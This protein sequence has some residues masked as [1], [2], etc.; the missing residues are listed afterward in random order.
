MSTCTCHQVMKVLIW[1]WWW[2]L[3]PGDWLVVRPFIVKWN[4]LLST[5][6]AKGP[7]FQCL[8][9][10]Q[11]MYISFLLLFT[12]YIAKIHVDIYR[13]SVHTKTCTCIQILD[14]LEAVQIKQYVYKYMSY[15]TNYKYI[16]ISVPILKTMVKMFW[17]LVAGSFI[18]GGTVLCLFSLGC[19]IIFT[20]LVKVQSFRTTNSIIDSCQF[21]QEILL[22]ISGKLALLFNVDLWWHFQQIIRKKGSV[23]PQR[24]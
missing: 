12:R 19:A 24:Q 21:V 17:W 14:A 7:N 22:K 15:Y 10:W 23:L 18:R 5:I 9:K 1:W 20:Y 16:L 2:R 11:I 3:S 13:I 6:K 4:M 8:L